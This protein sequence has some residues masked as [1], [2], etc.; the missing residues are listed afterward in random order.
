MCKLLLLHVGETSVTKRGKIHSLLIASLAV[1]M[2][3]WCLLPVL[4]EGDVRMGGGSG[5]G[6]S[7]S[8]CPDAWQEK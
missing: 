5:H 7:E 4:D 8:R 1:M 6:I 2:N 3:A